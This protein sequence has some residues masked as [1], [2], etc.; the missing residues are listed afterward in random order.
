[1]GEGPL[2]DAVAGHLAAASGTAAVVLVPRVPEPAPLA[3]LTAQRLESDVADPLADVLAQVQTA[4]PALRA[5]GGRLVFVLPAAPL[6]GEPSGTAAGA[7][8][9]GVLS[10]A[11]TLAIELARDGVAVNTLAVDTERLDEVGPAVAAQLAA[12]LGPA[13]AAVTGQQVH[14]TAGS[15][16]GRLRP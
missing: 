15:D 6:M 12:L 10:M 1:V 14:V 7:V 13:G 16:L 3:E 9:G 5:D 2:A 11:R 4:V 8:T